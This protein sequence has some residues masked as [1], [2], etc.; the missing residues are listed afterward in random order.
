M[1]FTTTESSL[2][3]LCLVEC[4]KGLFQVCCVLKASDWFGKEWSSHPDIQWVAPNGTQCLYVTNLGPWL[5]HSWLG[6]GTLGFPWV[7]GRTCP[8]VTEVA[9]VPFLK[10]RWACS[11]FDKYDHL[12][13]VGVLSVG[14]R[15]VIV[16][17]EA[18]MK[19]SQQVV[20]DS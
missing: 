18:L 20:N 6:C 13:A 5:P 3:I 4:C 2:E 7:Q 14:I 17:I 9:S 16:H 11:V 12:S 1:T 10:S 19:F 8:T 15:D